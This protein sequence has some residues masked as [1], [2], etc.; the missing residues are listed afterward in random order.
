[1]ASRGRRQIDQDPFLSYAF[2][3]VGRARIPSVTRSD[4]HYAMLVSVSPRLLHRRQH[5]LPS[6]SQC[7]RRFTTQ[8]SQLT[9]ARTMDSRRLGHG[10]VAISFDIF[11][12]LFKNDAGAAAEV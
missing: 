8:A 2:D 10:C 12:L 9:V 6:R 4:M 5:L 11:G 1:M 3:N 7:S